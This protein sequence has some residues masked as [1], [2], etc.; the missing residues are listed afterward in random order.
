MLCTL[1][2]RS[3]LALAV[4]S[5]FACDGGRPAA[6]SPE[7]PAVET[8]DVPE[9]KPGQ[10]ET[11]L[12]QWDALDPKLPPFPPLAK[13]SG[14]QS[15]L[16]NAEAIVPPQCYTRTQG[17]HNPCYV[18]HQDPIN[19]RGRENRMADGDLQ[20]EYSFSDTALTNHWTNLY[21]DRSK[22]VAAISDDDI[23]QYIGQDNY[24]VLRPRLIASGWEGYLPD[25][26]D[27][28]RG[29]EAFD[30]QG[31]AKDGSQ[32]VA[33]SYKPMP[34]TFWPTNGST[35]DV[36]IRLPEPFR[37]TAVGAPS[38]D[39]YRA[40]L[41]LLEAAIKGQ[42]EMAVEPIDEQVVGVDLDGS[43]E[44]GTARRV[45]RGKT[46]VGAAREVKLETFVYP[47]GTEFLHT[48]RYV[49][50]NDQGVT[51][52]TRMKEVRYM[53]KHTR[54]RKSTMGAFY[55]EE[56]QE[57]IEG[58]L[59]R[60]SDLKAQGIDNKF[61]WNLRGFIEDAE[62]ELRPATYEEGLFCM[63]CHTSIGSTIDKVFSFA[64]KVDGP[65]GWGYIDLR[66]M[67]DAP[68]V[69]ETEG[70][71]LTYLQRVGGGAEFRNNDEMEQRWFNRDGS[72]NVGL[73]KQADVHALTT[74]S[75]E[76]ALTLNK[77]Y[78]VIVKDQD[79]IKGRDASLRP[80]R[81]VFP[82]VQNGTEP[83]RKEHRHRWDIRLDWTMPPSSP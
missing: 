72:V 3:V 24:T 13:G 34:S 64:R 82:K 14:H 23:L 60:Y 76:R 53:V 20:G 35:D 54:Y 5:A 68:N 77:A 21:E 81:N 6:P 30:G 55:D 70:E 83:L 65:R 59:P 62:G 74:P 49:G 18:C 46:Y 9:L 2:R 22:Q 8:P 27:L 40:N 42:P 7:S 38:R 73:V 66:G 75:R 28:Q 10:R 43:G 79:F 52:S 11:L 44:I 51:V 39:V 78:R 58:N 48:V 57:K 1:V 69:G 15:D 36:M 31:F 12:G 29:S 16:Y 26:K 71:I 56:H 32:W 33:F 67:P 41:A 61:G 47:R 4:A 19:G 25:L 63:G 37:A 50:W 17:K 80:P 45:L